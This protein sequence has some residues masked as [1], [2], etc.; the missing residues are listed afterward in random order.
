MAHIRR[1]GITYRVEIYRE[2]HRESSTHPTRA[3]AKEWARGREAELE[4]S[5]LSR[6]SGGG[7]AALSDG[8][9][10][11]IPWSELPLNAAECAELWAISKEYFLETVACRPGFP[12]RLTRKPATWKA[13]EVIE[14]RDQNRFG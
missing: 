12:V 8:L 2:S 3:G 4:S 6:V 5:L 14:Y 13:G 7:L 11:K 9:R 10:A 1:R